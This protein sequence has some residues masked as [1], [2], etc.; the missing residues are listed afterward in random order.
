ML[1]KIPAKIENW[2]ITPLAKFKDNPS[3]V[4]IYLEYPDTKTKNINLSN[5]VWIIDKDYSDEY[6]EKLLNKYS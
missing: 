6:K 4:F 1:T 5:I 2:V 3:K